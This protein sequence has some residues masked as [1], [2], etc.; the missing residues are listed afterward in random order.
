MK[1]LLNPIC[2]M[3]ISLLFSL[4]ACVGKTRIVA[5]CFSETGEGGLNIFDFNSS[6]GTLSY[7]TGYNSGPNPSY[8]CF[9]GNRK[10][11]Y[12]I[13]EVSD[14]KGIKGGGLTT[15]EYTGS[16][17]NIKTVSEIPVPNGGPCFISVTPD[18]G[19]L[20]IA[21]YGGGSAVVVKLDN[22]GIPE[23]VCD[24]IIYN[25]IGEK[26]SHAHMISSDPAGNRIYV[27]DLG[28]DR[29]MIY[30]LNT[31]TGKLIPLNENGISLPEGTGPRHFVFNEAGTK[32]YVMGEL[33]SSVTVFEVSDKEGLISLQTLSTLSENNKGPNSSADIHISR[34]G[35]FLYGSNRGENSIVTY[36]IGIDGLLSLAGHSTCGGNWPRNFTID[37]SGKY[38]LVGN[39][40]SGNI[41]VYAIDEKSGLPGKSLSDVKLQGPACL[42]FK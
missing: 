39:Q 1:N 27:T 5:G 2:I 17:D 26:L 18:N 11:I 32:M 34:S 16:F 36:R 31:S 28:L 22:N 14:F 3:L 24:T 42:K 7:L 9:S 37:P 20:L 41:S 30:T 10:L 13:N 25:G 33:N 8:L 15:L 19:F 6:D 38:I 40:R 35:K 4:A 12:A 21:N 29:I 23:R